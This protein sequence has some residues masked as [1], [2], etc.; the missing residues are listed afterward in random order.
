MPLL[1]RLF[2]A[3]LLLACAPLASAQHHG[4]HGGGGIIPGATSRPTGLSEKD[5]LKDFHQALAVQATSQQ[6]AE[7][8]GIIKSANAAKERL[9]AFTSNTTQRE[10]AASVDRSIEDALSGSR[11]FQ[12]GFSEPQKSG[13]KEITKRLEKADADVDQET[14]RLDRA[15]QSESS[16]SELAGFTETL[17]KALNSFLNEELALGREMGITLASGDDVTFNLRPVRKS[18]TLNDRTIA[19]PISGMLSQSGVEG[20]LRT[21]KIYVTADLSDLQ[22]NLQ[23]II[24]RRLQE[25]NTCGQRLAVREATIMPEPPASSLVLRLHFERWSCSRLLG[26]SGSTEIAETDGTVEILLTPAIDQSKLLS[27]VPKFKRI[28]ASGML[29][30]ALRNG[31]L[32]TDLLNNAAESVRSAVQASADFK[33]ALPAAVEGGATMERAT[34]Q[35]VGAGPFSLLLEGQVQI[36][37]QQAGLLASQLNDALSADG[38]TA[39]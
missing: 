14:K 19:V 37:N 29:A 31:D 2:T 34:F 7:F 27:L 5:S 3:A 6:I 33:A 39:K 24:A 11:K 17:D 13:L 1:L 21:L 4:G 9:A 18:V 8:Q 22:Q 20:D 35:D 10:G 15:V 36:S 23:P 30:D 12:E 26:Q 32:G 25:G 38:N 16:K 28:D